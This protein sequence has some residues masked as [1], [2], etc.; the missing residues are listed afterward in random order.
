MRI[1]NLLKENVQVLLSDS[2]FS[3]SANGFVVLNRPFYKNERMSI[4]VGGSPYQIVSIER[5]E[6]LYIGNVSSKI[7]DF[8]YQQMTANVN[9]MNG[10]PF[11][12]IWN[13]TNRVLN[14][15]GNICIKPNNSYIYLGRD[16]FGVPMGLELKDLDGLYPDFLLTQPISDLYYGDTSY[17]EKLPLFSEFDNSKVES[18]IRYFN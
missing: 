14:L 12:K 7:F 18:L 4:F 1:T 11:L 2:K 16:H 3:I 9:P 17:R 13:K 8:L 15:N 5:N 6:D 10:L